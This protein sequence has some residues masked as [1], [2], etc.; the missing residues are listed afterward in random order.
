MR[1]SAPLRRVNLKKTLF[2][3][4]NMVT[5]ASVF[6]GFSAILILSQVTVNTDTA[7]RAAVLLLFAMLFDLLDG[8][9][10]RLT[11]TQS[12]FGLQLD[13]LADV[14][15]FGVAPALLVYKT[16]LNRYPVAGLLAAFLFV[17]CGVI[18]LARFNVLAIAAS[19][20]KSKP[21]RTTVGLPIPPAAAG[22]IALVVARPSTSLE[23]AEGPFAQLALGLTVLLSVLM[24]STVPFRSFK[25]LRLNTSTIL[26][27]SFAVGSSA[28]VWR[29]YSVHLV[30]VWLLSV[31]VAI[32]ILEAVR[33]LARRGRQSLTESSVRPPVEP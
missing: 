3:L 32:G 16:A 22:L 24:V 26:L 17:A 20:D 18:R 6:C 31:Y 1:R 11:R 10:A 8:R 21:G 25:D 19:G 14:I 15:S 7:G 28:F 13:S 4:P 2:L 27:V 23:I 5:L 9:V 12:S 33:M 30:L 29:H